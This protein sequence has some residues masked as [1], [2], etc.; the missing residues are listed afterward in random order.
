MRFLFFLN[1][2]KFECEV[3]IG[4]VTLL[5]NLFDF[6]SWPVI[7]FIF[8][9]SAKSEDESN[10][11]DELPAP[12]PSTPDWDRHF[13]KVSH[14][15]TFNL[16]LVNHFNWIRKNIFTNENVKPKREDYILAKQKQPNQHEK[17]I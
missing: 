11:E 16:T 15:H 14:Y 17:T 6:E 12:I 4:T 9:I 1:I 8:L 2:P 10:S 13:S 7:I 5:L 3:E